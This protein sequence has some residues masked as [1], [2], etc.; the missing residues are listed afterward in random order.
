[1]REIKAIVQPFKVMAITDAL[2]AIPGVAGITAL[3][4]RG[5]GREPGMFGI[6]KPAPGSVN[7][8]KRALLLLVVNEDVVDQV[9]EAITRLAHTGNFGDGVVFLSTIDDAVRI[10]TGERGVKAL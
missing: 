5:F 2:Q 1:M 10:R 4:A 7:Y 9:I 8:T 3:E 6:E